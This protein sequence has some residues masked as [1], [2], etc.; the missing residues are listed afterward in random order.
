MDRETLSSAD[1][2]LLRLD[3]PENLMIVTALMTF[4]TPLDIACL[5]SEVERSL[6]PKRR[7]RQ[8]VVL[9]RMILAKAYWEDDAT[10]DLDNHIAR[11]QTILPDDPSLL[12]ELVSRVMSVGLD[13]QRPLWKFYLVEHFG[14]G[15]ALV[16]RFHHC[17]ADGISLVKLLLSI[18]RPVPDSPG[19][20]PPEPLTQET[21]WRENGRSV[22]EPGTMQVMGKLVGAG[23]QALTEIGSVEDTIRLGGSV[24]VALGQLLFSIPDAPNPFKG[25][26][27]TPKRA[28][29]SPALPL[30]LIKFVGRSNSSTVND[31]LLSAVTGALRHYMQWQNDASR[32][33]DL[34]SFVPIDLRRESRRASSQF[35]LSGPYNEQLG[36]QFGFAVL[37]LPV[38]IKD[39]I[40]RL[41][42]I[43]QTMD[44]LKAS[45]E[46]LVSNWVLNLMGVVPDEIQNIA[47]RFWLTKGSAVM[48][49]VA[50]PHHQLY[51][52]GAAIDTLIGWV[53]QSGA[54]GLGVSIFSNNGKVWLGIATDQGLIPDPER[55]VEYFLEEFRL[56]LEQSQ[57]GMQ[58]PGSPLLLP[59]TT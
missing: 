24:V 34:H 42:E 5:K 45:G 26:I 58:A 4:T 44:V 10:F 15:S 6:L 19:N 16:M 3:S 20:D 29:W 1:F 22:R 53:P 43:H 49:N 59:Q 51:L 55:I 9:P 48:T 35:L 18:T 27:A 38:S 7:F 28:A 21:R 33:L 56:L 2:A 25:A 13:F 57:Q 46:A 30:E 52:G 54:I 8:R 17:I 14:K 31:V 36:N 11:I 47:A 23:K 39:P 12:Q 40:Q 41:K 32:P 37:P 50:G